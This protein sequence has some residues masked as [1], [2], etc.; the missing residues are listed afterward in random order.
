MHHRSALFVLAAVAGPL[1]IA[2][3]SSSTSDANV[4]TARAALRRMQSCTE[5][6][7][8]L[9]EDARVKMH[10]RIDAQIRAIR[11]GWYKSYYYDRG[12]ATVEGAI[13]QAGAAAPS[14]QGGA[15][16]ATGASDNAASPSP[17]TVTADPSHSNTETQVEGVDE[18][19][20]VKADGTRLYVLHGQKF[21]IVDA[22]PAPNLSMAGGADIEGTPSE[23]FVADGKAV[24]FSSVDGTSIYGAAGIT[25]RPAYS[26]G[27]GSPVYAGGADVALPGPG[28][29]PGG[30]PS[31]NPLTKVTVLALD[32]ASASVVREMYFEGS[33]LSSRRVDGKV[34]LV[35]AG[36]AHG[37]SL[38]YNPTSTTS[39]SPSGTPV[40]P[41]DQEQI[42][43]W[44]RLRAKNDA[45]ID[46]TTYA[47]WVPVAFA[48]DASSVE[49][50]RLDCSS[51]YVPTAGS[52]EFGMTQIQAFD[53]DA[54][55][56]APKAVAIVGAAETVYG[57]A[58]SMVLAGR[59]YT[60][61]WLVQQQS[62]VPASAGNGAVAAPQ[63][64]VETLN[65]T[66]LHLFDVTKGEPGYVG[67]GTVPGDVKD[68]FALDE[69]NGT[70]RVT[71][72]EQRSGPALSDGRTNEVSHVYVL[73][74]G[75]DGL[76]L[77]GDAGEIAPG[78]QLYA[79]RY[80]GDKAYVVT[81]H[82]TDPLF[83]IDLANPSH[84]K[85]L[86]QLQ[87]PG[88]SEYMHPL[89][90]THLL[91][92][93][94]ETDDTGHQHTDQGYWYGLAIQ[95]FDVTDPLKPALSDKYV[96]D[97]GDY[98]TSEATQNHK[99]FTYFDD[100]K[101][102]AFPYVR[103]YGYG[104]TTNTGPSSTLEVF[105]VDVES[106]IQ[107][108]GSVDHSSLLATMPNGNYGYCGGYFD[109]EVR[110]GVFF[111]NVVYSISYGGIVANDVSNLAT[112]IA[113]LK[114]DAPTLQG[115]SCTQPIG[116]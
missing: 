40:S 54:P 83:V 101:L 53:L 15:T 36:G 89:D 79:T 42:A 30:A 25:P 8:S 78:E 69:K 94:R 49:A 100:R 11:E 27:Y 111:E 34:R 98:A 84:P 114:L 74:S 65:Y 51:F 77:V 7:E 55:T 75:A 52:T 102:L 18:A 44:Q 48:K 58:T 57:N 106:G 73:S 109:G 2:C 59:A 90:D 22:W 16:G 70:V 72:T 76:S 43:A 46:A 71:T 39:Y 47:D 112:P 19:D 85:V 68:Q 37:P 108:L 110:R 99:A 28:Y 104:T 87:I 96:Y 20:I 3:S 26:D 32:G 29:Y 9:R 107:K 23:M 35:L 60:D 12:F 116:L 5:L 67:S 62:F 17:S 10:E 80:V 64:P 38:D 14:G 103:Q 91:T 97:G 31:A 105:H 45:T 115:L 81:W 4:G 6:T 86:G 88:F 24:I 93:G 50:T 95:V 21:L 113:S 82:V 61:P 63:V 33:Y 13:P 66:H 1:A 41:S 92:I 56:E